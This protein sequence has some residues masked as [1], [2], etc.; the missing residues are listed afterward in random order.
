MIQGIGQSIITTYG[1]L[2]SGD[3]NRVGETIGRGVV[4]VGIGIATDG[5]LNAAGKG[6]EV[7]SSVGGVVRKVDDVVEGVGNGSF[8][9]GF[10][11]GTSKTISNT[12]INKN[13]VRVDVEFPTG[14]SSG[15]VHIQI[16]GANT[17]RGQEKIFLNNPSDLTNLP[18][19]IRSSPEI[20]KA[21]DK[22]FNLL[23]NYKP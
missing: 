7:L 6:I 1:N 20:Q 18:R 8:R 17:K 12:K 2:T 3:P 13:L 10:T 15:N 14:G 22:A 21:V 16:K 9:G 23:K 11:G 19:S 4:D 5:A